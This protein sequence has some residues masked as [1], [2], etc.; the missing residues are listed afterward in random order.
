MLFNFINTVYSDAAE[1]GQYGFQEPATPIMEGIINIHD[2]IFFYLIVVS[3]GVFWMMFT[4]LALFTKNKFSHKYLTHGT[5][6]EIVWTVTPALI[7]VS[8]AFPSFKLLYL[9]DEVID[10]GLTFKVVGHQWYWSYEFSDY[11][12]DDLEAVSFDSYMVPTDELIKGDLRLLEVDNR[13]VLPIK[14]PIRVI[15]TAADVLH[16]WAV[17]SLGIKLDAVPGRLNQTSMYIKREGLYYGQ[18]SE[19]CGVQHGFMPIVV[20]GVSIQKFF[21]DL[22]VCMEA[23]K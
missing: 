17:P 8:I 15:V 2:H 5:V 12:N 14:T 1:V 13:I 22:L 10:P 21:A 11:I 16:S 18:C 7:L 6:I 20:K 4:I 19:I 23:Y 9:M 3:V